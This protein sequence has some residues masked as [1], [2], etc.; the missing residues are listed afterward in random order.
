M[1][2]KQID[3]FI[4]SFA[5][6]DYIYFISRTSNPTYFNLY[7]ADPTD[8]VPQP[9]GVSCNMPSDQ[10]DSIT[11]IYFKKGLKKDDDIF[12]VFGNN[13]DRTW[14]TQI[15]N[16]NIHKNKVLTYGTDARVVTK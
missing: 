13:N 2:I 12:L 10:M 6:E 8:L 5:T 15:K 4:S 11:S 7:F 14:V 3:S 9:Y 1:K 16:G